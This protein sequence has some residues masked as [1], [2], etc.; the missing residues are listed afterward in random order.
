MYASI[1]SGV[2]APCLPNS[3]AT[4]KVGIPRDFTR[5][6][7]DH[8]ADDDRPDLNTVKKPVGSTGDGGAPVDLGW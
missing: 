6:E 8:H 4:R 1:T 5:D 2:T 3:F 7:I